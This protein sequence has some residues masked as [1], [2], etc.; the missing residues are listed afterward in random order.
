MGPFI[1]KCTEAA[2]LILR[3][4]G[5]LESEQ[6]YQEAIELFEQYTASRDYFTQGLFTGAFRIFTTCLLDLVS[7][8]NLILTKK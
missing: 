8:Q 4:L 6:K 7:F 2:Q 1:Y 5:Q 3:K